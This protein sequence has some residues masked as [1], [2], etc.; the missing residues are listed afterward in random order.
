[1][2]EAADRVSDGAPATVRRVSSEIDSLR[3][4]LGSIVAEL[5]RRRHELLDV[6]LQMRRHP[7]VTVVAASALALVLGGALALAVRGRR[8]RRRPAARARQVRHALARLL[9]HPERVAAEPSVTAR[10]LTAAGT[11][12][13]AAMARH[14]VVRLVRPA[15][16]PR[17]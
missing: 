10:I 17:G 16:S 5:D 9:A 12:A 6:R 13:G 1:M 2:G 7:A 3:G 4:E 15:G 11:A 8:Q 14:L